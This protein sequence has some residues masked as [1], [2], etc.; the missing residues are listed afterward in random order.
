MLRS[1]CMSSKIKV[2]LYTDSAIIKKKCSGQLKVF[3]FVLVITAYMNITR[4]TLLTDDLATTKAFY[5]DVAGLALLHADESELRFRAGDTELVFRQSEG[6]QP[7][8][9]FAFTIPANK[10]EEAMELLRRKTQLISLPDGETVSDFSNWNAKAFYFYDNNGNILEY[11]VRYDLENASDQPFSGGSI[12]CISEIGLVTDHVP[13]LAQQINE[14]YHIPFFQKQPRADHFTV[15]GD[16][17]GLFIIV[18][19]ERHWYPTTVAAE[20]F[21]II[22]TFRDSLQ[23]QEQELSFGFV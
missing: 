1:V 16:D 18:I 5:L 3:T 19:K 6:I 14:T 22:V 21:P 8:Y 17:N 23:Q 9:H 10:F 2:K 15:L 12:C 11:I 4:L 20:A 7:V 13:D